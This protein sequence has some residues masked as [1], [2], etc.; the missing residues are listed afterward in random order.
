MSDISCIR[1]FNVS[2]VESADRIVRTISIASLIR[3]FS[4]TH[5]DD[6]AEL[7]VLYGV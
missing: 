2:S 6:N 4:G 7:S 1:H 3:S 5:T